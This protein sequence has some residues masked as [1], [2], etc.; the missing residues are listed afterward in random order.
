MVR[1]DGAVEGAEEFGRELAAW[2][3]ERAASYKVPR[4]VELLRTPDLPLTATGKVSKRLLRQ[5]YEA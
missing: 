3:R 5:R 4:R 1:R 2:V